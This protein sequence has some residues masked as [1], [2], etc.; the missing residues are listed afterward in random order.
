MKRSNQ[1]LERTLS[2]AKFAMRESIYARSVLAV[3]QKYMKSKLALSISVLL[4]AA[5]TSVPPEVTAKMDI[6]SKKYAAV[7]SEMN[8]EAIISLLGP[9]QKEEGTNVTWEVRHGL[10]NYESLVVEFGRTGRPVKTTTSSSRLVV[11]SVVGSAGHWE[12]VVK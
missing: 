12:S 5:C 7:T 8:R 11:G 9:P 4:L 2:V 1:S 10:N 3:R 6:A